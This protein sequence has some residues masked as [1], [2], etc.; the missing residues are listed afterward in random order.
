MMLYTKGNQLHHKK[1]FKKFNERGSLATSWLGQQQTASSFPVRKRRGGI[2]CSLSQQKKRSLYSYDV[3]NGW[4]YARNELWQP[5]FTNMPSIDQNSNQMK[6][7]ST[8]LSYF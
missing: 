5:S 2:T 8:K 7:E 6:P 4:N 1:E 3:Y